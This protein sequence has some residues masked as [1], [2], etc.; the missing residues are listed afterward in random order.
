[1]RFDSGHPSFGGFKRLIIVNIMFKYFL[2]I[3]L[4][5]P[6]RKWLHMRCISSIPNICTPTRLH[7]LTSMTNTC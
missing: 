7:L 5:A 3:F 4:G 6:K 1:M 2:H